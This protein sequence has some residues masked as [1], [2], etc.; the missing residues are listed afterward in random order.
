MTRVLFVCTEGRHRSVT[1]ASVWSGR[2]ACGLGPFETRAVGTHPSAARRMNAG[3]LTWADLVICMEERHA[4]DVLRAINGGAEDLC[5]L[6]LGIPD[7]YRCGDPDLVL[8]L[9]ERVPEDLA[10]IADVTRAV[11]AGQRLHQA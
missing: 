8:M 4:R 2:S 5:L 6:T 10:L 7:D 9:E 1:G 11:A 3:D